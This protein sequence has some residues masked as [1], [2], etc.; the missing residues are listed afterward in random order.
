[1]TA[2]PL[3]ETPCESRTHDNHDAIVYNCII[4]GDFTADRSFVMSKGFTPAYLP[5]ESKIALAGAIRRATDE[6][7]TQTIPILD[8]ATVAELVKRTRVPDALEQ[9][10]QMLL[11]VAH[12]APRLGRFTEFEH[13]QR[14]ATRLFLDSIEAFNLLL[15]YNADY[16]FPK[17]D[18]PVTVA[19]ALSQDGWRRVSRLRSSPTAG[20]QAFVAMWFD[21]GLHDAY[22][23]GIKPAL[24]ATGFNPYRVDRAHHNT[25]IDAE[26]MAQIRASRLVIADSTGAR[27]SVYY[28]AGFADGLGIPVLWCCNR[29]IETV[30]LRSPLAHPR[31][32][33]L[34][35]PE[36]KCWFEASAFDTNHLVHILWKDPDHLKMELTARIRGLGLALRGDRGSTVAGQIPP[37]RTSYNVEGS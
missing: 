18:G 22:D 10:D 4:C 34:P 3:C 16:F 2:C 25:R 9:A 35:K 36:R 30:I 20:N 5:L 13:R 7:H 17:S 27:P 29:D 19:L 37:T 32:A 21:E 33:E 26:I 24:E 11:Y 28:E 6:K 1:M 8:Y 23:N 15:A 14:W 31:D 12:A